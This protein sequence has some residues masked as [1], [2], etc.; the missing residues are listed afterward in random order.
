[1]AVSKVVASILAGGSLD[2]TLPP[3]TC[4]PGEGYVL[5]VRAGN[6]TESLTLQVAAA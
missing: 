2:L 5:S 3:L 1:V 4:K 6:D